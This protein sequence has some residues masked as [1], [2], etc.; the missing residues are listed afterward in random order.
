MGEEEIRRM[1]NCEIDEMLK[2]EDTVRMIKGPRIRL[3]GMVWLTEDR[4]L[5][6]L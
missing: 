5:K 1:S 4:K 6:V 3:Y 2:G